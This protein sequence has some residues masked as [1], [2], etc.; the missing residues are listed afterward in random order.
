MANKEYINILKQ[1][2]NEWNNWKLA[3]YSR[4]RLDLNDADLSGMDLM[5][6][7]FS[8]VSLES[9]NLSKTNLRGANLSQ[10]NLSGVDL[11]RANI[12]DAYLIGTNLYRA[13]LT[14]ANLGG[15]NLTGANLTGANL[16][17]A[18]L[19][20]AILER[21]TL[22]NVDLCRANLSATNLSEADLSESNLMH[23]RFIRTVCENTDFSG[24]RIYGISVW[25]LQAGNNIKSNNIKITP[26]GEADITT[27]NLEVAQ[28]IYLMLNN[29][30]IRSVIDSITSKVVLI[31]G[32]FKEE[33]KEIL[34]AI[35]D[36]LR[37]HDY[38]PVMFDFDKPATR[39]TQETV[40][41]LASMSKF[42]VVD[43]TEPICSP[44]EIGTI[45]RELRHVPIQPLLLNGEIPW[46]M[47]DSIEGLPWVSNISYYQ[48][49]FDLIR[50]INE[51]IIEPSEKK[52]KELVK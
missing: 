2:I 5:R 11:S 28:F 45:V 9:A 47:W 12:S 23:S 7:D 37:K 27:D 20:F 22:K 32:R 15:T 17:E 1:D 21:A 25:D 30:K 26:Y 43:M 39:N 51:K 16:N 34:D 19:N 36:E 52:L 49:K 48:D 40:L 3:N 33:R 14:G 46:G 4:I 35:R 29:K 18:D 13:T 38:L 31:L 8:N 41:T 24:C 42:V 10:A 44:F 6:V 50:N